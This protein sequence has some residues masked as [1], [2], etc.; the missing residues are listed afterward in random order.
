M[1]AFPEAMVGS[2][3]SRP[4]AEQ[5]IPFVLPEEPMPPA[6]GTAAHDIYFQAMVAGDQEALALARKALAD[7]QTV[8]ASPAYARH[9]QQMERTY[10]ERLARHQD[11]LTHPV[12]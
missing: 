10:A 12:R 6:R 3:S 9:M 1:A 5:E 4:P 7:G 8:N 2:A 11:E